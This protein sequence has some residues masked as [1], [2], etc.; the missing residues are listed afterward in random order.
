MRAGG[1]RSGISPARHRFIPVTRAGVID[2]DWL[3]SELSEK[4]AGA[5]AVMAANNETGVLQPWREVAGDSAASAV[6]RCSAM[7]RNGSGNCRRAGSARA[8]S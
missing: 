3:R 8:I 2:L 1:G 7:R 6:C 5:V 4:A